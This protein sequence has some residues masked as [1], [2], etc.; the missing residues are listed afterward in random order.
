MHNLPG[1]V[2]KISADSITPGRMSVLTDSYGSPSSTSAGANVT[3][4]TSGLS[5]CTG[6]SLPLTVPT[7]VLESTSKAPTE[8]VK[9]KVKVG[10]FVL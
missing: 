5:V 8:D 4:S 6:M 1:F 10:E 9:P 7:P 2:Q 3:E